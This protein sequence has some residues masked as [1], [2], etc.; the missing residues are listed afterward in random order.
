MTLA[1][2][3]AATGL[4]VA[5]VAWVPMQ[6]DAADSGSSL[7]GTVLTTATGS[8][9]G[10]P[11]PT[12]T[13]SPTAPPSPTASSTPTPPKPPKKH[14]MPE[15]GV[16]INNPLGDH[17][18]RAVIVQRIM[19]GIR[20]THRGD[21][22]RFATYN[23]DRK[24][25]V[26]ALIKAHKRGVNVQVVV[27]D[28]YMA[29]QSVRLQKYLGKNIHRGSFLR[30]CSGSCRAARGNLHLKIYSFSGT[31]AAHDVLI[32]SSANLTNAAP[33]AQWNDAV[34]V[35][36]NKRLFKVWTKV[37]NQLKQDKPVK[38]RRI[39]YSTKK[40]NVA[41]HRLQAGTA[42]PVNHGRTTVARK[43][44]T[45]D[46]ILARLNKISCK[47]GPN[48]GVNGHTMIRLMEYAWFGSRGVTLAN[49][50]ATLKRQGCDVMS[51]MSHS[52]KRVEGIL[53]SA[54]IPMRDITWAYGEK[55]STDGHSI[56][57]G[58]RQYSHL[59]AMTIS[60]RYAGKNM[61]TVI[62]GSENWS[63]ISFQNDEVT[64]QLVGGNFYNTYLHMFQH[65]WSTGATHVIGIRPTANAPMETDQ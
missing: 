47:T 51:I 26:N 42:D 14:W 7:V 3:T 45:G 21:T 27:N 35:V 24:D 4:L 12:G 15:A 29:P 41:F 18:A 1:A 60:G 49:R 8:P 16:V 55:L 6:A 63:A 30:F 56:V 38:H 46:P 48:Y 22:I 11:S 20:H 52:D 28:N 39:T 43:D 53:A 44:T 61:K 57:Y 9:T 58:S 13:P 50:I 32:S 2:V 40:L 33:V 59:K 65:Q 64:M 62:T 54:G 17:D 31:G 25:S 5:T 37:F 36:G 10:S 34:T 23:L 19:A